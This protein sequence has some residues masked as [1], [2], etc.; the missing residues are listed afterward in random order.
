MNKREHPVICKRCKKAQ[1]FEIDRMCLGCI[2]ATVPFDDGT[3]GAYYS[4][5]LDEQRVTIPEFRRSR[6]D[7]LAEL[8]AALAA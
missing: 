2:E 5:N 3:D 8:V 1:T 6:E 7:I 4:V